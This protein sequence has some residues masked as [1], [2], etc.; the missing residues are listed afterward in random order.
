MAT[1]NQRLMGAGSLAA[2]LV[3]ALFGGSPTLPLAA[4]ERREIDLTAGRT[5]IGGEEYDFRE[6]VAVDHE[7]RILYVVDAIE[8]LGVMAVS[9]EDGSQIAMYGGGRGD[10]PGE[11]RFLTGLSLSPDG[12]LVS[13]GGVI[14]HWGLDGTL[15]GA[16]RPG[17]REGSGFGSQCALGDQP[18]IPTATGVVRRGPDGSWTIL[19]RRP[20][21]GTPVGTGM[22]HVACLEE[23][24]YALD[25]RL[26]RYSLDGRV[27]SVP[28]PPELVESS[29]RWREGL[30][31]GVG[32]PYGGLFGS[33]TGGVVVVLPRFAPGDVFGAIIDPD[34]GCHTMLTVA[35]GANRRPHQ[36]MGMYR[37]SVLVGESTV[38]ERIVNGVPTPVMFDSASKLVLRPLGPA[39]GAPCPDASGS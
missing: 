25:E 38:V 34:T 14:N 8:P 28:L 39:S 24:V 29:Q 19:G 11:L 5:I 13:G 20:G 6:L 35:E 18:V 12:I 10:G 31:Q 26:A 9:I 7:R 32:V 37:D 30:R 3:V 17:L 21:G 33:G 15:I 22:T 2:G 23:A 27:T 1:A 4:Q 36:L 16:W